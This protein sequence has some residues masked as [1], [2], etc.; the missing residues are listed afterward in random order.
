MSSEYRGD[1]RA[2]YALYAHYQ[3]RLRQTWQLKAEK[4]DAAKDVV[5]DKQSWQTPQMKAFRVE[6]DSLCKEGFLRCLSQ[7]NDYTKPIISPEDFNR[8]LEKAKTTYPKQWRFLAPLRNVNKKRDRA[9]LHA[10]KER[11]VFCSILALQRQ[12]NFRVSQ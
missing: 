6:F 2:S 7:W 8:F 12:A 11:Q 9:E 10:Y 5:I 3:K 4:A 1:S